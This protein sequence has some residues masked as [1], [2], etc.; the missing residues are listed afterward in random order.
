MSHLQQ[1]LSKHCNLFEAA[2]Q[3]PLTNELCEGVLPDYKL[4]TYLVQDLKFFQLGLNLFGKALACC[5]APQLAVV[6]GKQIGFISNDENTYFF[7]TLQQL[8]S[9]SMT[10]IQEHVPDMA[11]V[12]QTLPAVQQYLDSLSYLTYESLL[13]AEIVTFMYVMEKVYLG[14]A[15]YNANKKGEL[16]YKHSEW[17]ALHSG[18]AFEKWVGFLAA[19]VE[20]VREENDSVIEKT[21]V[22][23]L[24]LEIDFFNACYTHGE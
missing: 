6:L 9:T 10:E 3:H 11:G 16:E 17:I 4:Y 12:A 7:A 14:W 15:Q 22:T 5:D 18:A 8:E 1:L 24:Q 20:R 13:Y 19:E 2:T 21:L 23:T